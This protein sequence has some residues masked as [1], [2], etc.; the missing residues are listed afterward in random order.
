[1][2]EKEAQQILRK[3]KVNALRQFQMMMKEIKFQQFIG[4]LVTYRSENGTEK[5]NE[6][7]E[8][9]YEVLNNESNNNSDN[10]DTINRNSNSDTNRS[11]TKQ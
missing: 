6:K 7:L 3:N 2:E 5:F 10:N 8:K 9:M 11:N 1:M 4:E